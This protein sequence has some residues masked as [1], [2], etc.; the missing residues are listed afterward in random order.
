[1]L[2][3]SFVVLGAAKTPT[4][5]F[6]V[7]NHCGT[8]IFWSQV[9]H[10]THASG[11]HVSHRCAPSPASGTFRQIMHALCMRGY[12]RRPRSSPSSCPLPDACRDA[13]VDDCESPICP[14]CGSVDKKASGRK[15]SLAMKRAAS[16]AMATPRSMIY[17]SKFGPPPARACDTRNGRTHRQYR[18]RAVAVSLP[19]VASWKI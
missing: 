13:F 5:P 11:L 16:A 18:N 1:M 8:S 12:C 19:D 2:I 6:R 15:W 4:L 9:L 14:L 7:H 17:V 3:S 10:M